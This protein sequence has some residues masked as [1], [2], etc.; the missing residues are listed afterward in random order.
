MTRYQIIIELKNYF[1]ISDLV[2]NHTY[3]KFGEKSWQFLQTELLHTL[4]IVRRDIVKRP[5]LVNHSGKFQRGLRC[6]L[7]KL[8]KDKTL[9]NEIYLSSHVNGAGTDSDTDGLTAEQVR[10]LIKKNAH[11]LPYPIRIEAGVTW[12]HLDVY[13]D[14]TGNKVSEFNS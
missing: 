11:L 3:Q 12:L 1:K 4:L 5:M 14:G 8:V 2:C 9:K 13:D 7:C 6:N 10:A